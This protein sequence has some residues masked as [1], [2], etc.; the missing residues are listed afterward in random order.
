L[1]R[2]KRIG[3]A[4]AFSKFKT[5]DFSKNNINLWKNSEMGRCLA[6]PKPRYIRASL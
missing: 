1:A 5:K 2:E 3:Q 4:K 6:M